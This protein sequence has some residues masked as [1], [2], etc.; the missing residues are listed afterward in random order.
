MSD[1]AKM[2][3]IK[4]KKCEVHMKEPVNFNFFAAANGYNGFRSYFDEIFNPEKYTKIYILKGGPGTGKSTMMK[5]IYS[6]FRST[7]SHSEAIYCSSDPESLDGVILESED[8]RVAVIDGTSPHERDAFFPGAVDEIINLGT[9]WD[10]R[11]LEAQREKIIPLCAEKRSAYQTAYAYLRAAGEA[12]RAVYT[13][14]K[15]RIDTKNAKNKIK[16]LAESIL[17]S[18]NPNTSVRLI[19]AFGKSGLVHVN[20]L[21]K[22]SNTYLG[23]CGEPRSTCEFL[24]LMWHETNDICNAV[25]IPSP[26]D[27]SI[28][29]AIYY[30]DSKLTIAA[31]SASD[32]LINADAFYKVEQIDKERSRVF[33]DTE[34]HCLAEAERWFNIAADLHSRL[35]GIYCQSMNFENNDAILNK[36]IDGISSKIRS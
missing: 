14:E 6:H 11:W 18:E 4:L 23:V 32:A 12:H 36:L 8:V 28:I 29:E 16:G 21:K 1:F 24:R 22:I 10:G 15:G 5:S 20:T 34:S 31:D 13:L 7:V 25:R 9:G 26:L 33:S 27:D 19:S 2:N 3:I 17:I 30:P 35:E